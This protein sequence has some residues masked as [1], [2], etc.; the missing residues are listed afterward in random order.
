MLPDERFKDIRAISTPLGRFILATLEWPN[1]S[2]KGLVVMCADSP[3]A[4]VARVNGSDISPSGSPASNAV[5]IAVGLKMYAKL[6]VTDRS[7]EESI[8]RLAL[9]FLAKLR[10][11]HSE[12]G[13]A[14]SGPVVTPGGRRWFG[15]DINHSNCLQSGSP[16]DKIREFQYFGTSAKTTDLAGG[17]V[18]V[19]VDIGSGRSEVWTFYPSLDACRAALPR[20]Q[21][22][23]P[24]YE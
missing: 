8:R 11:T 13:S 16:A 3:C 14:S 7:D 22:I 15:Q 1:V 2:E 24:K 12:S 6:I 21:G 20:S 23:D 18:E 10:Q 5:A 9:N 17:A 4:T 19:E